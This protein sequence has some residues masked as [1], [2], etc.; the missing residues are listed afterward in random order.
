[1]LILAVK[2]LSGVNE[3][4]S[5][6]FELDSPNRG[7]AS[8]ETL[9]CVGIVKSVTSSSGRA[10]SRTAAEAIVIMDSRIILMAIFDKLFEIGKLCFL[11][12]FLWE[13]SC[14]IHRHSADILASLVNKP[15]R[16]SNCRF[17]RYASGA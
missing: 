3:S 2:R 10:R 8:V 15:S 16:S 14:A 17:S 13:I 5:E 1:M 7:G 6:R 9:D 11:T 12:V 4:G